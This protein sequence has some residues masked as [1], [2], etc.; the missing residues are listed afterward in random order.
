[1]EELQEFLI[2]FRP[3]MQ[4]NTSYTLQSVNGGVNPQD[5]GAGGEAVSLPTRV[6]R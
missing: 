4:A 2:K 5:Q 6:S 3:D 1:M